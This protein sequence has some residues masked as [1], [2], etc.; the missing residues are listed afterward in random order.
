MKGRSSYRSEDHVQWHGDVEVESVVVDHADGE[1]HC[2]HDHVVP[3]K[4]HRH[5][6]F[7]LMS[8]HLFYNGKFK[9]DICFSVK[10]LISSVAAT[11]VENFRI[12]CVHCLFNT[13]W[14]VYT[15]RC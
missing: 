4:D 7:V 8:V 2:H 9:G 14:F 6:R 10:P 13:A 1:E 3:G 12:H 11:F 15:R 5:K